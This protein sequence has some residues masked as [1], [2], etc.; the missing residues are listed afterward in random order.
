MFSIRGTV[1]ALLVAASAFA[2]AALFIAEQADCL[3]A[4]RTPPPVSLFEERFGR[5][6]PLIDSG[7]PL[8]YVTDLPPAET[9][10]YYMA[11]YVLSPTQVLWQTPCE[12]AIGDFHSPRFIAPTLNREGY[13]I[14]R[15][16]GDG[17]LLL[18]R[19]TPP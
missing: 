11:R 19:R 4:G 8:G 17:V 7:K 1:A 15:D 14:L 9:R 16:L 6:R 10:S 5:L 3:S 18:E 2:S 13:V 12:R